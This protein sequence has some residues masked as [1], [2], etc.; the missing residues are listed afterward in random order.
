MTAFSVN[1]ATKALQPPGRAAPGPPHP[2]AS[3]VYQ[4][5]CATFHGQPRPAR[6]NRTQDDTTVG[7]S[8]TTK[9]RLHSRPG[10][11]VKLPEGCDDQPSGKIGGLGGDQ[12]LAR[13]VVHRGR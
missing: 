10:P 12:C 6:P 13:V 7:A 8:E 9:P 4:L 5:R 1:A 2:R 11:R 3:A